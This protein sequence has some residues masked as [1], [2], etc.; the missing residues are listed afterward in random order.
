M[1]LVDSNDNF[2]KLAFD[3]RSIGSQKGDFNVKII[4]T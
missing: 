3:V 4:T 1:C 2:K